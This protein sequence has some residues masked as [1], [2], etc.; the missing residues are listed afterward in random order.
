METREI[1]FWIVEGTRPRNVM[2]WFGR[3]A[4]VYGECWPKKWRSCTVYETV[5]T[6]ALGRS[7]TVRL[8]EG[9]IK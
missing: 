1:F 3:L 5:L 8:K 2:R 7:E 4:Y 9:E 6:D